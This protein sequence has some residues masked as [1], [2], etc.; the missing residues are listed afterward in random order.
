MGWPRGTESPPPM[1]HGL[2]QPSCTVYT[3]TSCF[4][5]QARIRSCSIRISSKSLSSLIYSGEGCYFCLHKWGD[6]LP[7]EKVFSLSVVCRKR[8]R[9]PAWSGWRFGLQE[10]GLLFSVPWGP[11]TGQDSAGEWAQPLPGGSL[12]TDIAPTSLPLVRFAG[13]ASMRTWVLLC[14]LKSSHGPLTLQQ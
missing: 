8:L 10:T 6:R 14:L 3:V 5:M 1:F 12:R 11:G 13:K 4:P 9:T 7:A 2:A